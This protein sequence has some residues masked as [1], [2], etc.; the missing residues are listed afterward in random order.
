MVV[1]CLFQCVDICFDGMKLIV[2]KTVNVLHTTLSGVIVFFTATHPPYQK[3]SQFHFLDEVARII[4][5]LNL[6]PQTC[7]MI[8]QKLH[9]NH[10]SSASKE[11]VDLQEK[12]LW[13]CRS[14]LHKTPLFLERMTERQTMVTRMWT[15][16]R[17]LSE[18]K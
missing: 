2:N 4:I 17:V 18:T 8:K 3:K 11:G 5:L 9:I 16:G 10:A 6:D 14:F 15:F 12:H 7:V 1:L 13:D